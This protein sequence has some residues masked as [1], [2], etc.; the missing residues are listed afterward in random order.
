M[1]TASGTG[2]RL[3]VISELPGPGG[4]PVLGNLLQLRGD[5]MHVVLEQWSRRYGDYFRIRMANREQLVVSNPEAIAAVLRDRPAGYARTLRLGQIAADMGFNGLFSANGDTWRRQRPL[6]MSAF[7]PGHVKAYFPTLVKVTDRFLR[8]WQRAAD[9]RRDI[10]LLA[11]LMRFTVDVTAGLAFGSDINT[12]E[13]D[14]ETIQIHLDKVFPALFRRLLTPMPYWRHFKLPSDRDLD[15]HLAALHAAVAEFIDQARARLDRDPALRLQPANLIEALLVARDEGAGSLDGRE[16]AGNVLTM[17]LAGEDTTANTLGWM[18]YLLH[19]HPRFLAAAG[20]AVTDALGDD[21]Y[22]TRYDQLSSLEYLEACAHE[23]M[24]LKPVAP[25]QL[26]QAVQDRVVADIAVPAG[27]VLL[28]LSRP[29]AVD[30]RH[31]PD[32]ASFEPGRWL[33]GGSA[34][35]SGA[36]AKRV[37]MSFGGGPRMCPGRYLAM[38]EM[39]MAL[40]MLLA[41]FE[42]EDVGTPDGGEAQERIAFT[43]AP[44]GLRLRLRRRA[45]R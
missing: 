38:Q 28:C 36:S 23:T 7:D 35:Q 12:L 6:V 8:R 1:L 40:A 22:P 10:D 44:H 27:T 25:I 2:T 45:G 18:I 29:A 32:A 30:D 37:T 42:I 4:L 15:R 41:N 21:P 33:A 24:R 39:K 34:V 14:R 26:Q 19:K 5:R 13:S 17:L 43:M 31:F 3:R 9:A 11:D 16:V 20:R